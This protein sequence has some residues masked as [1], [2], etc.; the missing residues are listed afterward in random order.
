[1]RRTVWPAENRMGVQSWREFIALVPDVD[2]G[3]GFS[4]GR[5]KLKALR[6][7]QTGRPEALRSFWVAFR[8]FKAV[9]SLF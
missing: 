8:I 3:V 1:M 6:E 5:R 7:G 9:F 2:S 4:Q